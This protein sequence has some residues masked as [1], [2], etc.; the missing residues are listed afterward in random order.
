M[1]TRPRR[2]TGSN[3]LVPAERRFRHGRTICRPVALLN[4]SG[5]A[6]GRRRETVRRRDDNSR[7]TRGMS[8]GRLG[9]PD[10]IEAAMDL[11]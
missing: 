7:R 1:V 5:V 8:V 9:F 2:L 3:G 10:L 6:G 4:S 11:M